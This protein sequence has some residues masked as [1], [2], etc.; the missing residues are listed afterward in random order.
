VFEMALKAVLTQ[1][2]YEGI[3]VEEIRNE[4]AADGD[5]FVL[6]VTA[7]NGTELTNTEKLRS[8]LSKEKRKAEEAVRN[9]KK[10]DSIEDVDAAIEA[11]KKLEEL[12][13]FDPDEKLAEAK[14]Q[15]EKQ[16]QDQFASKSK[17]LTD[18][19]NRVVEEL[20][21]SRKSLLDQLGVTLVDSQ[22][23][24]AI[25]ASSCCQRTR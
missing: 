7:V 4:Y 6:Q 12:A 11:M 24:S 15:F 25:V 18:Q 1:E 2:E 9:L 13:E 3:S 17:Q 23:D 14:K 10:F 16:L 19:H 8:A 22:V 20:T 21:E 5:S